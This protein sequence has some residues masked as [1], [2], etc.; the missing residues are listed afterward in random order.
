MNR[1]YNLPK[2]VHPIRNR[3]KSKIQVGGKQRHLG[4]YDTPE[5]AHK[6]YLCAMEDYRH[7]PDE[8][9][10]KYLSLINSYIGGNK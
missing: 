7:K 8:I 5:E 1:K 9:E 10:D 2:G 6:A 4:T 3:F